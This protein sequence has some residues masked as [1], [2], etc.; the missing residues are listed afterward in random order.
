MVKIG[1]L[2][3]QR[4]KH[5]LYWN[6][7]YTLFIVNISNYYMDIPYNYTIMEINNN[8]CLISQLE[9]YLFGETFIGLGKKYFVP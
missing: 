3:V 9:Y 5:T 1:V 2:N 8:H 4:C 6:T 7:Y